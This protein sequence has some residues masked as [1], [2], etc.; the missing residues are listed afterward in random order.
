VKIYCCIDVIIFLDVNASPL[1]SFSPLTEVL[2]FSLFRNITSVIYDGENKMMNLLIVQISP[3]S[4][5]SLSL[6]SK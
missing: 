6:M 4:C 5:Y 3:A 1:A 2:F